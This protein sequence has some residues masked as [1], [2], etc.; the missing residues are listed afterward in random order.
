MRTPAPQTPAFAVPETRTWR[1]IRVVPWMKC[2]GNGPARTVPDGRPDRT[3]HRPGGRVV[4]RIAGPTPATTGPLPDGC[5]ARH[6]AVRRALRRG[7]RLGRLERAAEAAHP[8]GEVVLH[9][10]ADLR[11]AEHLVGAE[12]V[13]DA[14]RRVRRRRRRRGRG[15]AA[16]R[17]PRAARAGRGRAW[18]R[19]P[20][21]GMRSP[22]ISREIV[23]WSTPDC[24]ASCRCDI[25]LA[26]SWARSHSL[27][28][29]PFWVVIVVVMALR[30]SHAQDGAAMPALSGRSASPC[31]TRSYRSP[32]AT[33]SDGRAGTVRSAPV[34]ARDRRRTWAVSSDPTRSSGSDDGQRLERVARVGRGPF[35][36]DSG[37]PD[38]VRCGTGSRSYTVS[39]QS[40][41]WVLRDRPVRAPAGGR[42]AAGGG[43]RPSPRRLR[44]HRRRRSSRT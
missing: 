13:L 7:G 27:N 36:V 18:S 22:R 25:F 16:C 30:W 43:S 1:A 5:G 44:R 3:A 40:E 38:P 28:A 17:R 32:I 31:I 39:P 23:E 42:R 4:W 37:R 41:R 12:G 33:R 8:D 2:G 14:G 26:L 20:S 24:W 15:T 9:D 19:C 29:R 11:L 6:R 21:D 10:L 34:R 35:W